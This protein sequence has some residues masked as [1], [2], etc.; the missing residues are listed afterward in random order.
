MSLA[1]FTQHP[2]ESLAKLCARL[3]LPFEESVLHHVTP[4]HAIGGNGRAVRNMR[5]ANYGVEILALSEPDFPARQ[6]QI[7]ENHEEA[8]RIHQALTE[9]EQE[10][11]DT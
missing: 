4:G 10:S 6:K 3:S 9:A 7:I 5:H 2:R 8:H 1:R 11:L